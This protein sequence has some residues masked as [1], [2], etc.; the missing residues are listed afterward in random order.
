VGLFEGGKN[1][2]Y[3]EGLCVN[4]GLQKIKEDVWEVT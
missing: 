4:L 2:E 3:A 1:R